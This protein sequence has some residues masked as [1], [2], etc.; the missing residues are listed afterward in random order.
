ME[1]V[2]STTVAWDFFPFCLGSNI[3]R[4]A[5]SQ[6][7]C[8]LS[9]RALEVATLRVHGL[10]VE[11]IMC[12]LTGMSGVDTIA[13]LDGQKRIPTTLLMPK[14]LWTWLSRHESPEDW[15]GQQHRRSKH[16]YGLER[17]QNRRSVQNATTHKRQHLFYQTYAPCTRFAIA[18]ESGTQSEARGIQGAQDCCNV[19]TIRRL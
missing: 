12:G 10:S 13:T 8:T 11:R 5:A 15:C 6:A 7:R 17:I 4:N 2:A 19:P 9:R 14:S 18:V 3:S 1:R 16:S